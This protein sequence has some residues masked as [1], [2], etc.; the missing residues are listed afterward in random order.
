MLRH[1]V[2]GRVR[3]KE[4]MPC[5]TRTNWEF[6]VLLEGKAGLRFDDRERWKPEGPSLWVF[7]PDC[8]HAWANYG[9]GDF[10]RVVL[11]FSTVPEQLAAAVRRRGGWLRRSL[12]G[13]AI[14]RV[15]ALAESVAPHFQSPTRLSALHFQRHL[16]DL[17][18]LLLDGVD[19][20]VAEPALSDLAALKT[21][22]A[23]AWYREHL[24]ERPTVEQVAAAVHVSPSHLRRLFLRVHR[25]GPKEAFQRVR[26]EKAHELM[27][28]S[29]QTL[30]EVAAASGYASASHLCREHR[31]LC[32]FTASTW[33][34]SLVDHFIGSL[35]PRGVAPQDCWVRP[36]T[37][38]G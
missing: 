10:H 30:D 36:R 18:L 23:L 9:S 28:A 25:T 34:R 15:A 37:V 11:H 8:S 27:G 24:A 31:A 26:L 13:P 14:A 2:N 3:W 20:E 29:A 22:Q 21:E 32:E 12:D 7:A 4:R 6:Y 35:A 33:R 1:Y 38:A 19:C 16:V 5:H 17:S